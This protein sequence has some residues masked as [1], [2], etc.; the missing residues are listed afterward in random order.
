[1]ASF[2]P[3][4][5]PTA[6]PTWPKTDRAIPVI[7]D[8]FDISTFIC[9]GS[10]LQGLAFLAGG[11][12]AFLPAVLYLLWQVGDIYAQKTGLKHNKFTDGMIMGKFSA[13]F[14]DAEGDFGNK[15]ARES[16]TCFMIGAQANSPLGIFEPGFKEL[17]DRFE[18]MLQVLR[19]ELTT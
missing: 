14:P 11:R 8:T 13:Q 16:L 7:K 4:F 5:K 1:M 18:A 12:L 15:P 10:V 9:L 2:A 19:G 6:A 17:G 3:L